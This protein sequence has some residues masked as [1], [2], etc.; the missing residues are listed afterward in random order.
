MLVAD[1]EIHDATRRHPDPPRRP[2]R[3]SHPADGPRGAAVPGVRVRTA[4]RAAEPVRRR[5]AGV[6]GVARSRTAP[7]CAV[8]LDQEGTRTAA[9]EPTPVLRR[10]RAHP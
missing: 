7:R 2:R 4:D 9:R 6:P 8:L 10:T 1:P 5:A 3:P